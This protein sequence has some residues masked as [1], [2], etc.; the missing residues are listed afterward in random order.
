VKFG[1]NFIPKFWSWSV[2]QFRRRSANKLIKKVKKQ[3]ENT[4]L[5]VIDVRRGGGFM[6]VRFTGC[7]DAR[8]R[9]RSDAGLC[10]ARRLTCDGGCPRRN[11]TVRRIGRTTTQCTSHRLRH[12]LGL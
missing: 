6:N 4:R 11:S 2:V 1:L 12:V 9:Q 8:R 10:I 7:I 5:P 3:S